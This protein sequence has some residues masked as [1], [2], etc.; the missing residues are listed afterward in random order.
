MP[1]SAGPMVELMRRL[2]FGGRHPSR[3]LVLLPALAVLVVACGGAPAGPATPSIPASAVPSPSLP[4]GSLSLAEASLGTAGEV[5]A[6]V[7][8]VQERTEGLRGVELRLPNRVALDIELGKLEA[9][10]DELSALD[11]G[12]LEDRLGEPLIRL[13]YR[14]GEVE[15]AV[16]DFRT[17]P[18]P[19]R[20][21]DH[22][23]RDGQTFADDVAAFARL[24]GC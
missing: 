15:L 11:L 21:V 14:L 23:E 17:N 10:V 12:P 20:A 2:P 13:G 6:R 8:A 24:A 7:A 9:A 16:E 4:A 1:G 3:V 18:R 19:Q 22:V 5:C